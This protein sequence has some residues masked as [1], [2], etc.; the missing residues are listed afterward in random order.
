MPLSKN[1]YYCYDLENE[2]GTSKLESI[3][4]Y[5]GC[6]RAKIILSEA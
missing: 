2:N 3:S 4:L 6:L 1:C 5:S